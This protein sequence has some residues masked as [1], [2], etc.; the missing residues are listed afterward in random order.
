MNWQPIETAPKDGR[1]ILVNDTVL[2]ECAPFVAARWMSIPEWSG[3]VYDD[4]VMTD[5]NPMGPQP[6]HW[7]DVPEPPK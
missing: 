6:S 3:W 1:I 5:H 7:F 4:D 2:E